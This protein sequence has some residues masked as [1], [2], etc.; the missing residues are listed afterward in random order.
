ME[1]FTAK[2]LNSLVQIALFSVLPFIWWLVSARKKENF[3]SWIGLK[4]IP[5]ENRK[6]C[7]LTSLAVIGGFILLSIGI[8]LMMRDVETATSEFSGKGLG[9]LPA[10]FVYAFLNTALPEELL[11]RGFLLKRLSARFGFG[12]ANL[13]QSCLFGLLHGIMFFSLIGP[14]QALII[15]VFTGGIGWSMGYVNEKKAN[16]SIL[17]SWMIHGI[18]NL[19][20][21]V[22]A[23]S[24][25]L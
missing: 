1:L 11:F 21:A 5:A 8:L 7:Y 14:A 22:V 13:A 3:F 10:A 9:V 20:S 4:R 16:G 12:I 19:F 23:M 18:A 17:P 6:Q 15:V 25:L 24:S 2:L